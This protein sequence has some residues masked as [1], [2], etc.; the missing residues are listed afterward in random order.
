MGALIDLPDGRAVP[1]DDSYAD[2]WDAMSADQ[3][4][5]EYPALIRQADKLGVTA[6]PSEQPPAS[7]QS[8]PPP[9]G[10]QPPQPE[11]PGVNPAMDI[12]QGF[13]AGGR[14]G[15]ESILAQPQD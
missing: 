1:V 6:Q 5:A 12:L 7:E 11:A 4:R 8:S 9:P 14:R 13:G 3:R 2:Q 10:K 15:L